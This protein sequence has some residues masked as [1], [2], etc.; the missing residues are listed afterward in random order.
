[1]VLKIQLFILSLWLLFLLLLINK[2]QIPICFSNCEFLSKQE[3]IVVFWGNLIPMVCIFFLIL[4][5]IFYQRFKY[6]I[7]SS[8]SLPDQITEIESLNWEHLTFL[9][10][11]IIPLLSFDLDFNLLENRNALMFFLV[12]IVIGW[13]YVKTNMFYSN[14]TLALL[15][16][17][18]YKVKTSKKKNIILISKDH[19]QEE[20]WVSFKLIGDNIYF[21]NKAE[22]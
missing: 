5:V 6:I 18:I 8:G 4:G 1:M 15:G 9:V 19:L 2:I 12:L 13:I 22:Q 14:P 7:K 16:Y 20:N 3:L 10:T 11:Y 21:A 17:K